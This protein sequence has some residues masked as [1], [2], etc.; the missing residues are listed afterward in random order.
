MTPPTTVSDPRATTIAPPASGGSVAVVLRPLLERLFGGPVPVRIRAWDGSTVGPG[1]GTT[2]VLHSPVALRRLLWAPGSSGCAAPTSPAT[3][4]SRVRS[5]T[6]STCATTSL[7]RPTAS[8]RWASAS[9]TCR[10]CGAPP[11]ASA[12]LG[13]PPPLPAEEARLRGW[14]HGRQRDAEAI[15]HH[16]DVGNDFYRLVLGPS[17]TYSCAYWADDAFDLADAQAA[18]YELISRKL[19][20]KPGMRLL[21]IGCGWGGMVLHA[22]QHHGVEAVGITLSREQA[23]LARG[24]VAEAGLADRVDIRV[25]DYRDVVDEPFDAVSSI[26]MFEHVGLAKVEEYFRDIHDLLRPGARVLNHAISRPS[27]AGRSAISSRSFMG[28]Y[29]FPDAELIEVGQV[30]TA[31]QRTGLEVRD[32]ESLREHY[33]LHPARLGRQPRAGLGPRATHRGS[34]P[35][36]GVAPLHGG[37]GDGLRAEPPRHPPGARRAHRAGRRVGY[38]RHPRLPRPRAPVAPGLTRHRPLTR[39]LRATPRGP[40]TTLSEARRRGPHRRAHPSRPRTVVQQ[41]APRVTLEDVAVPEAPTPEA[42][43]TAGTRPADALDERFRWVFRVACALVVLPV[44]VAAVRNGLHHWVPTWDAA[45]TTV[46][47]ND[48]FSRHPPLIGMWSSASGWSG[49]QINFIGALQLYLLAIP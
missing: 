37:L 48:V 45:T 23:K 10:S 9:V 15:S 14:R 44:Y 24:R 16:Y 32:L 3:S 13:T 26:G 34:R 18:K 12:P 30:V 8:S 42:L 22:A 11:N 19:D 29:V 28:R 6:S 7:P 1:H 47:V 36:P 39:A 21:D 25:Q 5:S 40:A 33:A 2:V 49:H 35:G 43:E 41:V 46:R 20:L 31:M 4:T 17:L 27:P 38:P